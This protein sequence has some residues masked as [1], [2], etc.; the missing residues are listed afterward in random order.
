MPDITLA[1]DRPLWLLLLLLLPLLWMWSFKSLSGLGRWRRVL[2]LGLRTGVFALLVCALAELQLQQKNDR[3]TV[4]YLLDQSLSIPEEHREA[5]V[6][7][8]NASVREHRR[9]EK[10]DRVGVIVFGRDAKVELPPVDFNYEMSRVE[11][12][13]NEEYTN[14]ESALQRA[15]SLFP[16]DAA[17]RVV[18]VTDGNENVGNALGQARAMAERGVSLDVLPVPIVPRSE[19]SVDKVAVPAEARRGQ[20]FELRVVLSHQPTAGDTSEQP[21]AGTLRIKRKF[22]D[23]QGDGRET[24]ITEAPIELPPG[25]RVFSLSETIDEPSS[26]TYEAQFIPASTATDGSARNNSASGFTYVRGKGQVLLIEDFEHRGEFDTLVQ[27]LRTEGLQVAVQPSNRLFTSLAELQR[28]DTVILANVPRASGFGGAGGGLVDSGSLSGFDDGQIEMLVRNTEELGCGLIMLGGDRSFGAGDWADTELEKAMPVDFRIKAAKVT[29]VGALALIMH[30]SEIPRGN[31]WQKV[32]AREAVKVLGPR[33]YCGLIQWNGTD[34]WLWGQSQGGMIPV[35]PSRNQMMSRI[36]RLTV[37]DMPQFDPGMRKVAGAF[38]RLKNPTPAI[39]HCIII[40]DGDPSKPTPATMQLFIKQK[41]KITTVMVGGHGGPGGPGGAGGQMQQTMQSIASQTGGKFYVVRN[42]K[43]LPR[44]YQREARRVA[45]PV[46]RELEPAVAPKVVSSHQ[47]LTGIPDGVPPISGFV[48]TTLKD[49]SLVDVVL[50]SPVPPNPKNATVLATWT[51]GLGKT[52]AFT[53]DAGARWAG[54]WSG[55]Q[56]YDRFF[57]QLVRWS[58]RPTGDTAGYTVATETQDG[59]TRVIVDALDK[60]DEFINASALS[61]SAV[62]PGLDSAPLLF[63]QTAPGRYIAEFDSPDAGS[64]LLSINPGG[65]QALIRTG[66]NVG[67]SDEFRDRQ[68]NRPLLESIAELT[69][70]RGEPG[71]MIDEEAGI[72]LPLEGAIP[73]PLLAVDPYRRDLPPAIASQDIWPL[74]VLIGS[75]VFLADVFVR[76]VQIGFEWVEP[77]RAWFAEKI[78]RRETNQKQPQTMARLRSRKAEVRE[79]T[80]GREGVRFEA[81]ESVDARESPL[82]EKSSAAPATRP[83]QSSGMGQSQEEPRQ[84]SYTERLLKAKQRAKQERDE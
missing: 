80:T 9:D 47:I 25:K 62:T 17:K 12:D 65:G 7:Y 53:T 35:G 39:K 46:I 15:M 34:Q 13:L 29:P 19:V 43:A 1:V 42:P 73:E 27:R 38:T 63:E 74:L 6:R 77:A 54:G 11:T 20:P 67:Y 50:Q 57:S 79:Q 32:I 69:P 71:K 36:D 56:N 14:L 3:M 4:L 23:A 81:D 40:S 21:V 2:A 37:G 45:Q 75:C 10:E 48:Q 28:F 8:V 5:M 55:W 18:V 84:E 26:Y 16:H 64:Y 66:V 44:I 72:Q 30:A 60:N 31:H 78:L 41:V 33:D 59:K 24:I 61:G 49:S 22:T 70:R 58:M 52:A 76:R 82:Q 83:T 51:Y 68:T